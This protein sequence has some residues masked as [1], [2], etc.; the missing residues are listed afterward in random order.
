MAT[1]RRPAYNRQ[2][3]SGQAY[4][5]GNTVRKPEVMP[6]QHEEPIQKS[7]AARQQASA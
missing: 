3:Y 7:A 5:Y 2:M 4:V 1:K 6:R